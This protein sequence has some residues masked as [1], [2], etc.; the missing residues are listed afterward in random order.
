[1]TSRSCFD[2]TE[3]FVLLSQDTASDEVKICPPEL[4]ITKVLFPYPTPFKTSVKP[5]VLEV[6]LIASEEVKV[7]ADPPPPSYV[8]YNLLIIFAYC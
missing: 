1:M 4:T 2:V 6:Q 8:P 5:K 3:V 7:V